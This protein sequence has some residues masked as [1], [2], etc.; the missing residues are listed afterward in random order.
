MY[1]RDVAI[2]TH[3]LDTSTGRPAAGV[4]VTLERRDGEVWVPA[5]ASRTDADGRCRDLTGPDVPRGTYRLHFATG[6]WFA[7]AGR[8][9]F[10]PEIT[11][12]FDVT[13][14]GHHHVPL[15]LAPFGYSTYRGS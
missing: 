6:E 12:T 7:A 4:A 3:V 5:G 11:V 15:L 10:H 1:T 8:E 13:D 9:T 2:T 14:L